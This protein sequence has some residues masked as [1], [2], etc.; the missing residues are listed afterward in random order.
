MESHSELAKFQKHFVT[1]KGHVTTHLLIILLHLQ[2][3]SVMFLMPA[4]TKKN[5]HLVLAHLKDITGPSLDPLQFAYR[6]NRS[7]DDAVN[8]ELHYVLQHLDRPG[9]YV[10]IQFEDFSTHTISTGAPQGCVLSPLLF[11]LYCNDCTSIKKTPLSS[12]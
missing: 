12:S 10:R 1:Q 3:F 8:M 9:S 7:V 4:G 2:V 6:A 5:K 11:S